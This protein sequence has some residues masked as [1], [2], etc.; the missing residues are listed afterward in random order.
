MDPR[1]T[2]KQQIAAIIKTKY[3]L[4][5]PLWWYGDML[6][7]LSMKDVTP[8]DANFQK[9]RDEADL[10]LAEFDRKNATG[11]SGGPGSPIPIGTGGGG[12]GTSSAAGGGVGSPAAFPPAG[13]PTPSAPRPAGTPLP[14]PPAPIFSPGTSDL[15]V[16]YT[17]QRASGP[18]EVGVKGDKHL[19][20]T[21]EDGEDINA[22]H[23]STNSYFFKN[24]DLDAPFFFQG[25]MVRPPSA[26]YRVPGHIYFR[27][28]AHPFVCGPKNG[29]WDIQAEC[30]TNE[31]PCERQL[32]MEQWGEPMPAPLPCAPWKPAVGCQ[33]FTTTHLPFAATALLFRPQNL[34]SSWDLRRMQGYFPRERAEFDNDAP[35]TARME[36][37]G[38]TRGG[39]FRYTQN[40]ARPGSRFRGGTCPGG[41]VV[42]P[43]ELSI[44]DYVS[45]YAP[46]NITKSTTYV[47]AVP[48][49][50]W[51]A[52]IATPVTGAI[53]TG[54]RWG[55]DTSGDLDFDQV[56][57][58]GAVTAGILHLDVLKRV[59]ARTTS[60][61]S[62][63]ESGGS[64]GGAIRLI[65]VTD[66]LTELDYT[67]ICDATAGA[68]ILNLPLASG[69]TGRVY[70]IKKIDN[71][72]GGTVTVT[73]A[74]GALIDDAPTKVL[75][76]QYQA[77]DIKSDGANWWVF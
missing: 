22:N 8:T 61:L 33:P 41:I 70:Q 69:C 75:N 48:S 44:D 16:A 45:S 55:I 66:T 10:M 46:S 51:A 42:L 36:P 37:F 27:D 60:P 64:F 57:G 63:L 24:P 13:T 29:W 72:V 49:V 73:P 12:S 68:I 4:T 40:P 17:S 38:F 39:E 25:R 34:S 5:G 31:P 35:M 30:S 2:Y 11:P 32:N 53:H 26:G 47:C 14:E 58:L 65:T 74:G 20:G 59:G 62:T 3:G 43:P 50:Y 71:A 67:A 21:T 56:S 76:T 19:I 18:F 23:L 52:G 77:I 54:Y 9:A 6:M 1:E 7:T 15:V 28:G